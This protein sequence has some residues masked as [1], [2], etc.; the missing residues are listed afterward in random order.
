[1]NRIRKYENKYQVLITPCK[2][3]NDGIVEMLGYLTDDNLIK[4]KIAEFS[5]LNDALDES[6]KYPDLNWERLI[7][8]HKDI[9]VE[10][11]RRIKLTLDKNCLIYEIEP[12]L[13]TGEEIKQIIFNRVMNNC[14]RF[15]L[16]YNLN[17]VIGYHIINPWSKNLK[18]IEKI[19]KNDPNLRI[20]RKEEI[21]GVIRFICNTT[22]S[23]TY[24][25]IVWPSLIVNWA[26]WILKNPTLQQKVKVSSLNDIL[27]T[28][29]MIDSSVNLR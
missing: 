18:E 11:Y 1:M 23:T 12:K 13:T 29:K 10:L 21:N 22:I 25:I 14:K 20:T 16:T 27:N 7:Q 28:Q 24:E 4:C 2:F 5:N 19:L 8:F 6:F 15:I 26:K 9:Y 17:D 3:E